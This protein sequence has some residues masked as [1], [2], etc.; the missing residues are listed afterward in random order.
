MV[1]NIKFDGNAPRD[2]SS[3]EKASLTFIF[4][5]WHGGMTRSINKELK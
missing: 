5:S 2:P 1:K 4:N 3:A